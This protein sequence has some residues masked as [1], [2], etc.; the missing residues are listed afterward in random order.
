LS[1]NRIIASSSE[2]VSESI[3]SS[4]ALRSSAAS[5]SAF[6]TLAEL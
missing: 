1:E 5:R 3:P 4:R 2:R 6:E